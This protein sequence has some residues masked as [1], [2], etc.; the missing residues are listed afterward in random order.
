M[1][2]RMRRGPTGP[3]PDLKQAPSNGGFHCGL[4]LSV[5]RETLVLGYAD[6]AG[7]RRNG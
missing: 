6:G 5:G 2:R 7:G 4:N 1:I 3:R